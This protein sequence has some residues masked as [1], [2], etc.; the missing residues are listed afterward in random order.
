MFLF[1]VLLVLC[2][3]STTYSQVDEYDCEITP[4][5][6]VEPL[7]CCRT[8]KPFDRNNFPECFPN[9]VSTTTP[10]IPVSEVAYDDDDSDEDSV[11]PT[12]GPIGKDDY[13][14][15]WYKKDKYGYNYYPYK[16]H[17]DDH[18]RSSHYHDDYHHG[19][20]GG[21]GGSG[22]DYHRFGGGYRGGRYSRQI[23]Y[24]INSAPAFCS[25]ECIFN[26]TNIIANGRFDRNIA[27][28]VYADYYP[29][30]PI[31]LLTRSIDRCTKQLRNFLISR[32]R[33]IRLQSGRNLPVRRCRNGSGMFAACFNREI[34]RN[35]PPQLDTDNED[36]D[37]LRTF[38]DNCSPT[39]G[40]RNNFSFDNIDVDENG[41]FIP[42]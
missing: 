24:R 14:T 27:V 38:I 42:T 15:K 40:I 3:S 1:S 12:N 32:R 8:S 13:Y 20:A 9:S 39:R 25:I 30:V 6:N 16:H 11:T 5:L 35:C 34:Y 37:T 4:P 19:G 26:Q 31:D 21:G 10:Q 29:E 2:L 22:S 36:C 17:Y 18:H 28:Q 33:R 23:V 41:N 7:S